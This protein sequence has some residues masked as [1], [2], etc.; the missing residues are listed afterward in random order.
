M[1]A[2]IPSLLALLLLTACGSPAAAPGHPDADTLSRAI[3]TAAEKQKSVAVDLD[4][5][6]TG[7]AACRRDTTSARCELTQQGGQPV[8]YAFLPDA[9][10][11]R[12][13]DD[14]RAPGA[15]PWLRLSGDGA[16][17]AKPMAEVADRIRDLSDP[18]K[19]VP[20]GATLA[21]AQT[22]PEGVSYEVAVPAGHRIQLVLD[23]HDRPVRASIGTVSAS[24]RDWG[25][26]V[27]VDPPTPD[28]L[29]EFPKIPAQK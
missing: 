12:I 18:R 15:K 19:L 24:Y 5:G 16:E 6:V 3:T 22:S 26:P 2:T 11:V 27:V 13:P 1:R 29:A 28:Q 17:L 25:A 8:T 4:L 7:R 10:F 21:T 20:A 23:G 14:H 9:S